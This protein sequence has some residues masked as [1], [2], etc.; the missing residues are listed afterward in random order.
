MTLTF[1][2]DLDNVML[3]QA[4]KYLG[5]RSFRPKVIVPAYDVGLSVY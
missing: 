3:N 2:F 4:T 5:Q 1:E